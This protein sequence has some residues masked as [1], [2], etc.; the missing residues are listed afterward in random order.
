MARRTEPVL[1]E[2]LLGERIITATGGDYV[3]VPRGTVHRFRNAGP[4]RAG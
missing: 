4:A 1:R 2:F 3:N